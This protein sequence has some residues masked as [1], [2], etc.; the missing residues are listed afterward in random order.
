M[1]IPRLGMGTW[2]LRGKTCTN[3][4]LDGL[5]IGYRMIDT[6]Q[7]Y[8]NE[9]RVGTAIKDSK[10][11]REDIFLATKLW[12]SNLSPKKVHSTIQKSL[13]RLQTEY[14]DLLYIHWPAGKYNPEKTFQAMNEL[15]EKGIVKRLGVSNFTIEL[16]KGAIQASKAPIFANQVEFHAALRS[17]KLDEYLKSENIHLVAYSPLGRGNIWSSPIL[18]EIAEKRNAS[19][20]QV[21]IAYVLKRGAITIPKASSKGHLKANWDA[22]NVKLT[23]DDMVEIEKIPYKRNLNPFWAPKWDIDE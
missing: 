14:I 4:L 2:Q 18:N 9:E 13:K 8:F 17:H 19:V 21:C 3:A 5:S 1:E 7:A 11:S 22:L 12:I 23:E 6:A 10:I 20:Q 15:V 16:V